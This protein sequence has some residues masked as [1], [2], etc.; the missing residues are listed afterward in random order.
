MRLRPLRQ[1]PR[2]AILLPGDLPRRRR[3]V[4]IHVGAPQA[5]EGARHT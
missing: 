4:D 1:V 5:P 3:Q 2:A